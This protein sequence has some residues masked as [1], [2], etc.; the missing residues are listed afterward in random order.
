[1]IKRV[2]E[3]ICF[4]CGAGHSGSTLLG[5]ILGSHSKCFYAGEANKTKYFNDPSKDIRF[6]SCKI[7]GPNC[8]VWS[9]LKTDDENDVYEQLSIITKKPLII[10]STKNLEWLNE[11]INIV[12][13][14][15]ACLF[16]IYIQRD[17]RAVLNSRIRKYPDVAVSRHVNDWITHIE[18]TNDLYEKF[19]GNKVRLHYEELAINPPNVIEKTCNFL[20]INYEPKM[21]NYHQF[22]H[23][24]LGGNTGTQYLVVKAHK[25]NSYLQL[26]SQHK[27]YYADHPLE[28]RLDLRW[29][30]ELDP[31]AEALFNELAGDLNNDF[32]WD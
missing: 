20:R 4:I 10:D 13:K 25:T 11:Q 23:H 5:L 9:N 1:M 14:T 28:I 7:C 12:K 18:L 15:N 3:K 21:I 24:P 19:E 22:E 6:K 29:K 31:K 2:N 30:R 8:N 16:L 17:G 32:K 27:S 26:A